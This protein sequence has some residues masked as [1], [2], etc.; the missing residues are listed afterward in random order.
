MSR[1]STKLVLSVGLFLYMMWV[2]WMSVAHVS[3]AF[4]GAQPQIHIEPYH[5]DADI[6]MYLIP[7]LLSNTAEIERVIAL[8]SWDQH[9]I[10]EIELDPR[11]QTVLALSGADLEHGREYLIELRA[12]S[13][14]GIYWQDERGNL[15]LA[16]MTLR[17]E[18][19]ARCGLFCRATAMWRE[20][21]W[22]WVGTLSGMVLVMGWLW[23]RS[24][25]GPM[26]SGSMVAPGHTMVMYRPEVS[27]D[28]GDERDDLG[29]VLAGAAAPVV[30]LVVLRT[31]A[32]QATP[33]TI[34]S[35]PFVIGRAADCNYQIV[36]DRTISR[37]HLRLDWDEDQVWVTQLSGG[38]TVIR[39]KRLA[40]GHRFALP[41][42]VCLQIGREA[43]I[44]LCLTELL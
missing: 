42:R 4:D 20:W 9:F 18:P 28:A 12:V 11:E 43:E 6:D 38:V 32:T 29:Q 8:I 3:F 34:Q 17:P 26:R 7:L 39:G 22:L 31:V 36:E 33:F 44:E 14:A 2:S 37:H 25:S 5:Y 30:Q 13:P 35:Y 16:T 1:L 10:A 23:W 27:A 24:R 21:P 41:G 40:E 15:A 19:P